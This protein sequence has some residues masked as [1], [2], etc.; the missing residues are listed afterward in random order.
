[1]ATLIELSKGLRRAG[2]SFRPCR[3]C[4]LRFLQHVLSIFFV[5][6]HKVD[7]WRICLP[8]CWTIL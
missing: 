7:F 5:P 6:Y 4:L 1:M 8:E 3:G 2:A